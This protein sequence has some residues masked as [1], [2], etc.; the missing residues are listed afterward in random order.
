MGNNRY[1]AL[2]RGINV[3]GRNKV[4]MADLRASFEGAGHADVRT[5]I[6]SGNVLFTADAPRAALEPDLEALIER[7][8]AITDAVVIVRSQA[9]L[10]NV[11]QRAP[12]GFGE[13]PDR[14]HFDVVF[15]KAPLSATQAMQVV[16]LRDG[17]DSAWTGPGAIYFRRL[18]E[19]RTKSRLS[20]LVSKP[21]YQRMTIR[22]WNTTTQ[23]LTMLDDG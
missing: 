10:R 21:E 7:D 5:Y 14:F 17:V 23:L 12:E 9:R 16:D 4:P 1:V 18:S 20:R 11:V 22:N 6:Q 13:E 2:L 3:G 15:L 19:Q 8:F